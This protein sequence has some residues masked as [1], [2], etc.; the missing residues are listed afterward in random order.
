MSTDVHAVQVLVQGREREDLARVWDGHVVAPARRRGVAAPRLVQLRTQYREIG[1]PLL[2]YV[3]RLAAEDRARFV[4]VLIPEM[5]ESR[6]YHYL[7]FSHTA[8]ALRL[9]LL[10]RGGPQV[11]VVDAP[12]HLEKRGGRVRRARHLTHETRATRPRSA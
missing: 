5:V 12:W 11:V 8:T 9:M 10:F 1:D 3:R 4:A 7:L 2:T 6:W